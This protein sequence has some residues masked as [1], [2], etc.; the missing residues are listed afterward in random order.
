MVYGNVETSQACFSCFVNEHNVL[1]F[2]IVVAVVV[3]YLNSSISSRK[4]NRGVTTYL[5]C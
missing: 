5:T 2:V 4:N 3:S 1:V